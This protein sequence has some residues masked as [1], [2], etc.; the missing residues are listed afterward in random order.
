MEIKMVVFH[1]EAHLHFIGAHLWT[2]TSQYV[3]SVL[4]M[5]FSFYLKSDCILIDLSPSWAWKS[6]PQFTVS[7]A[8]QLVVLHRLL[9]L[10]FLLLFYLFQDFFLPLVR[11]GGNELHVWIHPSH[12]WSIIRSPC[13]LKSNSSSHIKRNSQAAEL[14]GSRSS[15]NCRNAASKDPVINGC[16]FVRA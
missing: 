16:V 5:S 6:P 12:A 7:M 14:T 2:G 13:P 11:P 4:P 10:S 1:R 15:N 3:P 8:C 9:R